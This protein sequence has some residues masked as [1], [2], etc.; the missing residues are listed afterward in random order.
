M[1]PPFLFC[2]RMVTKF[3]DPWHTPLDPHFHK[4]YYELNSFVD[5]CVYLALRFRSGFRAT[6]DVLM[7]TTETCGRQSAERGVDDAAT[8]R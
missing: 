4:S 6:V 1:D 3:V 7:M 8:I 2:I 5:P